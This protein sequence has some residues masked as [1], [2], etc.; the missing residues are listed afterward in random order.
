MKYV[1]DTSVLIEGRISE[2]V[3]KGEIKGYT[4]TLVLDELAYKLLLRKIEDLYGRNPL[5]VLRERR[6][7]IA[8]ATP[9]VEE[10]LNI[11]LGIRGLKILSIGPS[12][13]A[14]FTEY[15]KNYSLLPRDALHLTLMISIGCR[16]IASADKD[17][18]TVPFI[19]R[20]SPIKE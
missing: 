11:I 16:N 17:F 5:E 15:M 18:D 7:A 6:E 9:Y 14:Y 8:Q 12:H 2:M 10:G 20:W 19:T 4:S 3:E 13:I 1:I